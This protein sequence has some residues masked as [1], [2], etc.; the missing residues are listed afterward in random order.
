MKIRVLLILGLF[1]SLVMAN[2]V[3][4]QSYNYEEMTQEQYNALLTEWQQRLDAAKKAIAEEEA[5]IEQLKKEYDALQAEIDQTWDEI[6]KIAEANKA[7]YEAY[8]GKVE[9][10]RDEVRAFLNLSPE[11]I[12]SKSN[13]LNALE[14]KLEELK[15]DPFSAMA[16]QEAMLNEIASLIEQ[17]KEKAKTAVPP[18][19]T[20]MKGDYLWKI[21]GKDDIYGNPMAWW[22]IYTSNLDQIKN[23]DL[24]YP[25]QVLA[26]PR[27]VGP[28]EHLV[29]KGEFLSKIASYP[30]VYGD[31]FKWQKLY[32]ANKSFISDPN[33]IYPFQV[34]KIA[35]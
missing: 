22:R 17:A 33:L 13:E 24:I 7:A 9:Q 18:T 12:Y 11:E 2:V 32:E 23:P 34:L 8:K 6:F 28:N 16:E 5:K 27:V 30:N 29:Q 10:L 3:L 21:A 4:A 26:I 20:V 31:S 25:N 15:K 14:S 19:Y 35:R 1:L